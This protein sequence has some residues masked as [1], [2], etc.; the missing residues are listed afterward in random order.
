MADPDLISEAT[1]FLGMLPEGLPAP[2]IFP[3]LGEAGICW[4]QGY[5]SVEVK[6]YARNSPDA[7]KAGKF[8]WGTRANGVSSMAVLKNIDD[9]TGVGSVVKAVKKLG[10]V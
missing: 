4:F 8:L 9:D 10:L 3:Y 6:V 7:S 5:D 1:E 2:T